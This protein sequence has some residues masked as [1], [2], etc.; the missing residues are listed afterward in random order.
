M[1]LSIAK[2]ILSIHKRFVF[3]PKRLSVQHIRAISTNILQVLNQKLALYY[4][5]LLRDMP[6]T[7]DSTGSDFHLLQKVCHNILA[8]LMYFPT[9]DLAAEKTQKYYVIYC[10]RQMC[11][12]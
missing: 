4:V 7:Q 9:T 1:E 3:V 5:G 2:L 11:D 8:R 10:I 6:H 12:S